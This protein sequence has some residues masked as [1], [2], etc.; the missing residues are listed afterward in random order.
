LALVAH[1]LLLLT[2]DTLHVVSGDEGTFL[3]MISSLALDGDLEFRVED[4]ERLEGSAASGRKAVILQQVGSK[5]AYSKPSTYPLLVAPAYLLLGEWGIVAFNGLCLFAALGLAWH[6]L[7]RFSPRT[8]AAFT[9]V[10][11][12]A[13][14]ALLPYVMWTMSDSLQSSLALAGGVL[15]LGGERK[16]QAGWSSQRGSFLASGWSAALGG[17]LLGLVASMRYPNLLLGGALALGPVLRRR[18]SRAVLIGVM[19]TAGFVAALGVNRALS[20]AAV[21]YK[22]VRATFNP[23]TGYPVGE[24]AEEA[25]AQFEEGLATHRLGLRPTLEPAVSLYSTLY[26]LVGRHTGLL[27]YFPAALVLAWA[28]LRRPDRVGLVVILAVTVL[29]LFYLVWMPRN[30]FGGATFIGN[31]Y[32]LT[33]YALMVLGP[34]RAPSR[35]GLL[36]AWTIGLLVFASAI[37]SSVTTRRLDGTSQ[38]HAYS[39]LFRLFPYESTAPSLDG[40]RDRY[41]SDELV[42][43]V[44]PFAEVEEHGFRLRTG[45]PPAEL[46]VASSREPGILRFLVQADGP[47]VEVVYR[48]WRQRRSFHLTSASGAARG[49]L[50]VTPSVTARLHPYWWDP[51]TVLKVRSFRLQLR[52]P[53][54]VEASAEI[55]YAGTNRLAPI[56]FEASLLEAEIPRRVPAGTEGRLRVR[57][58]NDGRRYWSGEDPIPVLFGYRLYRLPLEEG[59]GGV[60]GPWTPLPARVPS[61]SEIEADVLVHWPEQEGRYEMRLDL[62]V[63]GVVWFEDWVGSPLAVRRLQIV[64][65]P[66]GTESPSNPR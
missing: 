35:R 37:H 1:L 13:T 65:V 54:G 28:A 12:A 39:G 23:I 8:D 51:Q 7:R 31:R 58:R 30:Y 17:L 59:D 20:G 44:D 29:A 9:L 53:D 64:G 49:Y 3:A 24:G 25:I 11:F 45:D 52:A 19:L 63:G 14:G 60:E 40:R 16:A 32:F 22:A 27:L 48:D 47:E 15:C 5:L 33:G 36:A 26:F 43:F 42:R 62:T 21:P 38:M 6:F 46:L 41:W 50:G 66:E 61:R 2:R 57:V 56:F 18:Y 4:R 55:R 34:A 10:T